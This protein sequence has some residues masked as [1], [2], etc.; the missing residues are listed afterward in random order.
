MSNF[1]VNFDLSSVGSYIEGDYRIYPNTKC[2]MA[3][4]YEDKEI[5]VT[6]G[7]LQARVAQFRPLEFNVEH[8][9]TT[10]PTSA[11]SA[12]KGMFGGIDEMWIDPDD[13]NWARGRARVPV[14]LADKLTKKLVSMEVPYEPGQ[15]FSGAAITYNP[16]IAG[17]AM[18]SANEIVE[19][20][21]PKKERH[22]THEGQV[23]AQHYHDYSAV[24]G[25]VCTPTGDELGTTSPK[26]AMSNSLFA[27]KHEM[28]MHQQVHDASLEHG[29]KCMSYNQEVYH[30]G[31]YSNNDTKPQVVLISTTTPKPQEKSMAFSMAKFANWLKGEN[32]EI[33]EE[34]VATVTTPDPAAAFAAKEAEMKAQI[35][36]LQTSKAADFASANMAAITALKEAQKIL[37]TKEAEF[38]ALRAKDPVVFDAMAAILPVLPELVPPGTGL[39][40]ITELTANDLLS[41]NPKA[42]SLNAARTDLAQTGM[43]AGY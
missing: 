16:R 4:N 30:S 25:A 1:T 41:A 24:H 26:G 12:L 39:V 34:P 27:S 13:S 10:D 38:L 28:K 17:A 8:T 21:R 40:T 37:P 14:A 31:Y 43:Y 6:P 5:E 2:F 9:P 35:E 22:D 19:M 11:H 36:A 33:S 29:A 18:M 3:G 42:A 20:G 32:V 7:D 15:P 23:A